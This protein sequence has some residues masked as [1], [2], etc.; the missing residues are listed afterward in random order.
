ML[1]TFLTRNEIFEIPNYWFSKI[2]HVTLAYFKMSEITLRIECKHSRNPAGPASCRIPALNSRN[3]GFG[4]YGTF[5]QSLQ[6]F[7]KWEVQNF[8]LS[9]D[10]KLCLCGW[11][12]SEVLR[13]PGGRASLPKGSNPWRIP[14]M[15]IIMQPLYPI[16]D[17]ASSV[18]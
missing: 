6:K 14:R 5:F 18:P 8:L 16:F 9:G 13:D 15:S 3:L 1:F 17:L 2:G 12:R 4:H 7:E 10:N 11:N